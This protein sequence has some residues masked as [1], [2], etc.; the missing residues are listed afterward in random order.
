MAVAENLLISEPCHSQRKVRKSI[1]LQATALS[2]TTEKSSDKPCRHCRI[3][4][5]QQQRTATTLDY[6]R[7]TLP[8]RGRLIRG[9]HV[10]A[11]IHS[12]IAYKQI[13][14][15]IIFSYTFG[16]IPNNP[17]I[18]P[19]E[20]AMDFNPLTKQIED[21]FRLNKYNENAP[22]SSTKPL[23]NFPTIFGIV[24]KTE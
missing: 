20:A 3:M 7:R 8:V 23:M 18:P 13:H 16:I 17:C 5:A 19:I 15:P 6:F 1:F 9:H 24:R 2:N 21:L 10:E 4:V 22:I 14:S 11:Y 12:R